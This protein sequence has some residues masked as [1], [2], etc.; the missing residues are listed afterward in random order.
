M[1]WDEDFVLRPMKLT[2]NTS[3]SETEMEKLAN[4]LFQGIETFYISDDEDNMVFEASSYGNNLTFVFHAISKIYDTRISGVEY[5]I[6]L[7]GVII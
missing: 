5:L 6:S 4:E 1:V 3:L 7:Q 2:L